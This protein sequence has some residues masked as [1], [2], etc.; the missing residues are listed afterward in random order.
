MVWGPYHTS[1]RK[2]VG[3]VI[4]VVSDDTYSIGL[5][6]TDD[7]TITGLPSGGDLYQ[8]FYYVHSVDRA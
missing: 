4:G 1:I 3:D 7:N 8:M 5:F 6:A 2:Y